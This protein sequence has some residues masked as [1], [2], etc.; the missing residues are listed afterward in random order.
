[1]YARSSVMTP[2][3]AVYPATAFMCAVKV[4][5]TA[6]DTGSGAAGLIVTLGAV[7]RRPAAA[8]WEA[9]PATASG[10]TST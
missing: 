9:V 6:V 1:M 3:A 7:G 8:I 10:S 4:W 5:A 2:A